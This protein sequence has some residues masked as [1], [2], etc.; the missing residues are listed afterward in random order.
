MARE[1]GGEAELDRL[2]EAITRGLPA[3]VRLAD[4]HTRRRPKT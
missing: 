4:A 1:H 3:I 2:R